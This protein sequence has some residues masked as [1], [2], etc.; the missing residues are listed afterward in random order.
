MGMGYRTRRKSEYL[1]VLQKTPLK[2]K[3]TWKDHAIP[4]VWE[5]K[6]IKTHPHSKPIELQRR[7]I[8]ATTD[9]GDLVLDPAAGGYSVLEACK[10]SGRNFLGC[11][12][13]NEQDKCLQNTKSSIK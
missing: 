2:A 4:D 13:M 3:A 5:E 6:V 9:E 11:D 12:I 10:L 1:L 7:L 8:E